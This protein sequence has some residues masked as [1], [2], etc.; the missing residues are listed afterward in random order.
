MSNNF[1]V[2]VGVAVEDRVL[3]SR[4]LKVFLR[5]LTPYA[6]GPLKDT[7]RSEKFTVANEHGDKTSGNVSTTTS[8][9][10][11]YFGLDTNRFFP[12]DIVTGEQV[13]VFQYADEDEYYWV[14]AGRDD[15]LRRGELDRWAVSD[16]MAINKELTEDNTYFVEL[17]TKL[18]KRFRV[19]TAQSDGEAFVYDIVIDAKNS[20]VKIN[21][22]AGNEIIL[23]SA[24]TDI[25]LTNAAGSVV[26]LNKVDIFITA[27]RDIV[28]RAGRRLVIGAR[29]MVHTSVISRVGNIFKIRA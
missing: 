7:T 8:V 3:K 27:P 10:A 14:S 20:H 25:R 19:H 12:P 4:K 16:D 6:A 9:I 22:N 28:L 24:T 15:N 21:D 17:D 23:N 11:D 13:L 18:T 1:K 2:Y 29:E 26:D 5:E